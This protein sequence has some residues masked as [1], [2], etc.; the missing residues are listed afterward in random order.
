MEMM[1]LRF[2]PCSI[3]DSHTNSI[4]AP[5]HCHTILYRISSIGNRAAAVLTSKRRFQAGHTLEHVGVIPRPGPAEYVNPLQ[6]S[7]SND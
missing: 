6:S 7:S 2:H 1:S 5:S 3:S 4:S